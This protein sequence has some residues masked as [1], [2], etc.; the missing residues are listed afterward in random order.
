MSIPIIDD[1]IKTSLEYYD[2]SQPKIKELIDKI[3]YIKVKNNKNLTDEIFFYDKNKK[4]IF[5]SS[6]EILSAYIPQLQ[7]WKWSWSLPTM[8]KKSNFVSRKIL[9]YAF[10]L[11]PKK[12]YLLK[13]T[14]VNSKIKIINDLQ[15]DIYLGISANLSKKPFILKVYWVPPVDPN[16][17]YIPF[18]KINED[19]DS[20]NYVT[21]YLLILD[22]ES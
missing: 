22:Y 11:D 14:L 21:L 3:Y 5:K 19:P 15:L 1:F 18:K 6:Y 12:D 8:G 16:N 17:E 2:I 20:I 7:V 4:E 10:N 9:E 13:S